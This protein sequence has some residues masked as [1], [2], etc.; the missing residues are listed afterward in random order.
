[1]MAI[2]VG[3]GGIAVGVAIAIEAIIDNVVSCSTMKT[4]M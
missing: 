1:M 2:R 3:G 4:T